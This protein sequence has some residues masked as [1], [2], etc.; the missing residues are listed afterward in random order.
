MQQKISVIGAGTMGAGIAQVFAAKGYAVSLCDI[1]PEWVNRGYAG[2]EKGL[3]RLVSKNRL[4]AEEIAAIL[5]RI[6]VTTDHADLADSA[7]IVEA[8]VEDM[9]IKKELFQRL[10]Q[11]CQPDTVFAT[12]TSSFSITE[13]AS[14]TQRPDKVIGMHFF[15]PPPVMKLV[16]LIRGV[17]TSDETFLLAEKVVARIDKTPIQVQEAPGFVVNRILIPMINEAIFILS[18]DVASAEDIDR[19]MMLGANHP[20][21]PLALA[22]LIGNDVVLSIMETLFHE[23]GDSKYRPA[24]LLKKMVRAGLLGKKRGKGFYQYP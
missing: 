24:P 7:L 22:D 20:M 19:A 11:I 4:D 10:D 17:Y 14:A 21:G 15:N 3:Q 23:T 2:I 5:S 13:L 12:N 6:T 9:N 1:Q 8:I 18:E 16:E